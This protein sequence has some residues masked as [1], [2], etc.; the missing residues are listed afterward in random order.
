MRQRPARGVAREIDQDVDR[1]GRDSRRKAR[2]RHFA[3]ATGAATGKAG[4]VVRGGAGEVNGQGKAIV[5]PAGQSLTLLIPRGNSTTNLRYLCYRTAS[6][7]GSVR[8]WPSSPPG[9]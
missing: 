4:L 2:Q 5:I 3:P 7:T 9:L 1:I 8:A 6:G